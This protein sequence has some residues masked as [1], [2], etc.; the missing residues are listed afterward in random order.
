V[1]VRGWFVSLWVCAYAEIC[2]HY[3]P[4]H[5]KH[6]H[7]QTHSQTHTHSQIHSQTHAGERAHSKID[8]ERSQIANRRIENVRAELTACNLKAFLPVH[9]QNERAHARWSEK[10]VPWEDALAGTD[11][12]VCVW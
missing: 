3:T 10:E 9:T 5:T 4:T 6:L 11:E 12:C 8:T 2:I 7:I 1:R